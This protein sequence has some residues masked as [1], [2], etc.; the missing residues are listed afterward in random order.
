MSSEIAPDCYLVCDEVGN[1]RVDLYA[2]GPFFGRTVSDRVEYL[3]EFVDFSGEN[4]EF[5]Y[6]ADYEA[7]ILKGVAIDLRRSCGTE[8]GSYIYVELGDTEW[9]LEGFANEGLLTPN[10]VGEVEILGI[11]YSVWR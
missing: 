4:T 3:S 11:E 5:V 2:N 6:N 8:W 9:F 10:K 1:T 7:A